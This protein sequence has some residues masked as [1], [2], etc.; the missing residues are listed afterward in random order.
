MVAGQRDYISESE[1]SGSLSAR[2]TD[3]G[4]RKIENFRLLALSVI[5]RT[6]Y[7]EWKTRPLASS[8]C[9]LTSI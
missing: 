9:R 5:R 6:I 1:R 2:A 8:S 3:I 4:P 7:E